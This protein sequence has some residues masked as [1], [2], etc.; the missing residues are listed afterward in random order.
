MY[1]KTSL[2]QLW[3]ES[4]ANPA[5]TALYIGGVTFAVA[6]TVIFAMLFYA[7][8]A[9]VYP[10]YNRDTTLRLYSLM[11][12]NESRSVS[13]QKK[14]SP[15]FV[16]EHLSDLKNC[17]ALTVT[18]LHLP[19]YVQRNDGNP[20]MR[21]LQGEIDPDF[22][23]I[24]GYEFVAGESFTQAD[25]NAGVKVAVITDRVAKDLFGSPAE[26]VGRDIS[27]DFE[28]YRV[29]GV[30]REGSSINYDSFS[31]IFTPFRIDDFH[32]RE[33][34]DMSEYLG[35]SE[36]IMKTSSP[37]GLKALKDEI[38]DI[39]RRINAA[40]SEGW[41]LTIMNMPTTM[42]HTFGNTG[43]DSSSFTETIRPHIIVLLILLII[44][45]INISGMIGGQMGRR[46]SELGLRRSFGANRQSLCAQV[47]FENLI[48]TLAGGAIGL[49]VVWIV[50]A[51]FQSQIFGLLSTQEY[52]HTYLLAPPRVTAEILFAPAVF[53]GTLII[54]LVL[55]IISA[56]IPVRMALRRP[57]VS[58]LNQKR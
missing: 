28:P 34:A 54:C 48:L 23:K 36:V 45:A 2:K 8:I 58:S 38:N 57:I 50:M 9:P 3:R 32:H 37:D 51:C 24:Y 12:R 29:R 20:D 4:K 27:I 14:V 46:M 1:L 40:D 21:L 56:Y 55:N 42:E 15:L 10:E 49:V 39:V 6:F 26:A 17:E 16:K 22:F 52:A 44:P 47:M 35:Y 41:R 31:H 11:C 13:K 33:G 43:T 25:F 30:V 5:F 19:V 53:A 7:R 18:N